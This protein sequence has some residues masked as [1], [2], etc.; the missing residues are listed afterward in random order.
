M[1]KLI[2]L[3]TII[4]CAISQRTPYNIYNNDKYIMDPDNILNYNDKEILIKELKYNNNLN[5]Y[6]IKCGNTY[7]PYYISVA[8]VQEMNL[9]SIYNTSTK[10]VQILFNKIKYSDYNDC[11]NG[12]L[13]FASIKYN[14]LTIVTGSNVNR[15]ILT[16]NDIKYILIK[17]K[18]DFMQ[19]NYV[20]GL[21][22]S[23]K[24]IIEIIVPI[25]NNDLEKEIETVSNMIYYIIFSFVLLCISIFTYIKR[26]RYNKYQSY[27]DTIKIHYD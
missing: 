13:I 23:I 6:K 5:K 20:D 9:T 1:I 3:L 19:Q 14:F 11:N 27:L 15:F 8:I 10:F 16:E 17:L 22:K 18:K 25:Q 7:S 4:K 2:L 12:I 24:H 21:N 26:F